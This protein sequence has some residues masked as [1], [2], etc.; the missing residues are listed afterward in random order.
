MILEGLAV[1]PGELKI[2]RHAL[3]NQYNDRANISL[4]KIRK[5]KVIRASPVTRA[6]CACQ[7]E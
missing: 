1:R 7:I 5:T 3:S 4:S 2:S 6:E